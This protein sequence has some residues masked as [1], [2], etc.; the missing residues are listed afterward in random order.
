MFFTKRGL[1]FGLVLCCICSLVRAQTEEDLR[2]RLGERFVTR[3]AGL[4][5]R[6]PG[7]APPIKHVA[8]GIEIVRFASSEDHWSL[9]VSQ[10][11]LDK[12]TPLARRGQAALPKAAGELRA[13]QP[14]L[15]DCVRQVMAQNPGAQ[16]LRNDVINVGSHDT[17]M[18]VARYSQGTQTWL[19]QQAVI[20]RN[21]QHYYIFDFTTPSGRTL[22]DADDVEDTAEKMAVGIFSVMLDSV[23]LLDLR[24]IEADNNERLYR[25]R[26]FMLSLPRKIPQT[27]AAEQFFRVVRGGKDIGWSYVT[28][29]IG[30]RRGEAGLTVAALSQWA[31]AGGAKFD[32]ASEMFASLSNKTA[33]EQWVTHNVVEKDAK[34][35]YVSEFGESK[36]KTARFVDEDRGEADPA[37]VRQPRVR[38]S[39]QYSLTLSR[40]SKA[41]GATP[42]AR[43]LPPYYM[44]QAISSM[45]PRLVPLSEPKGYLFMVWVGS[46]G[47][48]IHRYL[49]VEPERTV[50]FF[51]SER[52]A[53]AVKDRIGLEGEPTYHYFSPDGKYLGNFTKSTGVTVLACDQQALSRLWPNATI[54]RPHVLDKQEEKP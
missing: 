25:T 48:L 6:P 2:D 1:L 9:R 34:K 52:R 10:M 49:D 51:G 12:P 36:K 31:E 35:D 7:E 15:D 21:D 23:Q 3:A 47:E 5:F 44:P 22:A 17:A 28:E 45:L 4:T 33:H 53:I 27:V 13:T 41:A 30:E 39:E 32:I 50:N 19:R 54:S 11:V 18:I 14:V 20:Q 24:P 37:D 38:Y 46:E 16:I 40:S 8:M 42:V 43:N 26:T 29:E